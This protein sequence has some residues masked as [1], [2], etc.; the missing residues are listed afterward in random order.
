MW[1]INKD[2]MMIRM[3]KGDTPSFK[4]ECNVKDENGVSNPYIPEEDDEFIFAVKE[5]RDDDDPLFSITIPNDTMVVTFREEHTKYLELGKYMYEV[6][7]NKGDYH[8]T[9]IANKILKLEAEIY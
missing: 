6:S 9:F 8:C 7:L 4:I 5:G 3:T 1:E 2:N